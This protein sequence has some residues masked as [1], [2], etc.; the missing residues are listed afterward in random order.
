[1]TASADPLVA[2]GVSVAL[3]G[4]LV[5]H[6]VD[7]RVGPGEF[8]VLLGSNGSGKSTLV[9]AA[10][11]LVPMIGGTV[12]L[13]GTPLARFREHTR[14]GYVPQRTR[15][16]AG[17][18]ATVH[19]VVLSG[20]LASRRWFAPRSTADLAAVESAIDRVGLT[21][22]SGSSIND[23]SG[24]QQQRA[25]IARALATEADLLV[26][27][28]PTAG[29]DHAQQTTLAALL[30]DLVTAGT[31]VLLVAHELGPMQPLID[32]AVVLDVG[33]V[34]HDGPVDDLDHD[35]THTHLHT[36]APSRGSI[37]GEGIWP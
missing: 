37:H 36:G 34:I 26:M 3:D 31:S 28:E 23:L 14:L 2:E 21:D 29:V 10:V 13:F 24:G 8:V 25:L 15:A 12:R 17:V 5:L 18:P 19:E 16:A 33:R 9:R 22:R 35:D 7:L 1:M 6:D 4:R 32:R 27:D 30:G 20:R 11:G